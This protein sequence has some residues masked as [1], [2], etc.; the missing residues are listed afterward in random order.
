M[1][2]P[3]KIASALLI[4]AFSLI[5]IHQNQAPKMENKNTNKVTLIVTSTPDMA[6]QESLQAY[7]AGVMP[8]LMKL[9]GTVIKRNIIESTYHGETT[10]THL[11]IMDFPSKE[12]LVAMFDGASYQ[13]LIPARDQAFSEVN[14][15]FADDL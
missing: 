8:M 10:F 2:P 9:G 7:V 13:A 4:V 12:A 1:K 15:L 11:L 5:S 3:Y 6:Q 14:I